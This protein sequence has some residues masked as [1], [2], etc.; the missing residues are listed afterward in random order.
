MLWSVAGRK[1]IIT[2][3]RLLIDSTH[4]QQRASSDDYSLGNVCESLMRMVS[5][6]RSFADGASLRWYVYSFRNERGLKPMETCVQVQ[7]TVHPINSPN[8]FYIF[9]LFMCCAALGLYFITRGSL[10]VVA[11]HAQRAFPLN[12]WVARACDGEWRAAK[13]D[14]FHMNT[15]VADTFPSDLWGWAVA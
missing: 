14:R 7:L 3:E 15:F 2:I 8:F 1:P 6:P 9:K 5:S 10:I 11:I 4:R 13:E 12:H